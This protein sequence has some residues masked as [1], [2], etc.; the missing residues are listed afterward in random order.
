MCV[1]VGRPETQKIP[2]PDLLQASS[3]SL[4]VQLLPSHF[5][6]GQL[7]LKCTA[8]VATLYRETADVSLGTS[9]REPI[10]ER[11]NQLYP[12]SRSSTE[13]YSWVRNKLTW[14]LYKSLNQS[15]NDGI[16]ELLTNL[17]V[18]VTKLNVLLLWKLIQIKN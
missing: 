16:M 3:L 17:S 7:I 4:T 5:H 12:H 1:Q 8:I 2:G 14:V 6:N 11:G 15:V 18:A 13:D 9:P 10:P